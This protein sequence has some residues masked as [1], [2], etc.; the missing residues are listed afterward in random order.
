MILPQ[1]K[2]L[3]WTCTPHNAGKLDLTFY[4]KLT[5]L[6]LTQFRKFSRLDTEVPGNTVLVVGSNA[7]GKTSILEAVYFLAT[8][9]SFHAK[10][11]R[12]LINFREGRKNLAVGRIVAEFEKRGRNLL[13]GYLSVESGKGH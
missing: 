12:E 6:S 7:Q 2:N 5:Q 8:M 11:D 1:T 10:N 3:H 13:L 4:M 9:S